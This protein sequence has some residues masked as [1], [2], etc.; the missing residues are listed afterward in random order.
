MENKQVIELGLVSDL[1]L[2]YKN[3]TTKEYG[4]MLLWSKG[5]R[6]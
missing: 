5:D 3:G 2:G 4:R 1:T 6:D